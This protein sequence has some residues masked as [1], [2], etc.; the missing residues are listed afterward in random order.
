MITFI[1][2]CSRENVVEHK[3]KIANH[4][5]SYNFSYESG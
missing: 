3:E 5:D 1:L 4:N 2:L